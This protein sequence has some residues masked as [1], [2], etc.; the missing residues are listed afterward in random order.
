MIDH[1]QDIR[2]LAEVVARLEG[3]F[4]EFGK[5]IRSDIDDIKTTLARLVPMIVRIDERLSGVA[6]ATELA[7]L[8]GRVEEQSK[9][10]QI[11]LAGRHSRKTAA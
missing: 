10:L 9:F 6:S 5:S 8:K 2:A 11:A 1:S 4:Q 7:E 3:Q